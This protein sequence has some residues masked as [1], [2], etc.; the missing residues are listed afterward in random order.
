MKKL[1]YGSLFLATIGTS[2]ISC[3]KEMQPTLPLN[4][5]EK[6]ESPV[7]IEKIGNSGYT[8]AQR[9]YKWIDNNTKLDCSAP[10]KGCTVKSYYVNGNKE[11][12]VTVNQVMKLLTMT[13]DNGTIILNNN[14]LIHEFP[15]FYEGKMLS[16]IQNGDIKLFFEFPYLQVLDQNDELIKVYNYEHTISENQVINKLQTGTATKK[17]SVNT[18]PGQGPWKCT[19]AGTNC[20]VSR[21]RL[22]IHWAAANPEY[23]IFP[24]NGNQT[25]TDV[26]KDVN[27]KRVL[28]RT[29]NGLEYGLEL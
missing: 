26:E 12:D 19:E 1:I 5:S 18:T 23:S 16:K 2:I 28:F 9:S 25:I 11:N 24:S 15:E 21:L 17:I 14:M 13:E 29:A 10:G 3:K 8:E 6:G 4:N 22:N 20:K 7:F 27:S